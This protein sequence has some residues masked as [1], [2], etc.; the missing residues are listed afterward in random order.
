MAS[1]KRIEKRTSLD[2][3]TVH[4]ETVANG[5]RIDTKGIF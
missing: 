3:E 2:V 1:K 5:G 4:Q